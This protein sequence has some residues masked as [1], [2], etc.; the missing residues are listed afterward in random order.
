MPPEPST[1]MA[2]A[3]TVPGTWRRD[4]LTADPATRPAPVVTPPE[5][6]PAPTAAPEQSP[7][8]VQQGRR[9]ARV[10]RRGRRVKRIVRRV[11]LWSVLKLALIFFLCMYAVGLVTMAVLWGFANSAG[12][13]DNFESFANEVGWEN[14][15]FDGEE[16]FRQAAVIGAVLV[17]AATLLSVL[18]TALLNVISELTG[19]IR[20]VVIEEDVAAPAPADPGGPD[21]GLGY[22]A[23]SPGL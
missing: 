7:A 8:P 21:R 3:G 19:G 10:P 5:A 12:L 23:P 14:W 4:A 17:V 18:A 22:D 11:E 9:P 13:V 16:M 6:A 1:Q 15:Q 2:S 20:L